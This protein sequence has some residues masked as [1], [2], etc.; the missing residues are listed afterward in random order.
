M[1]A[2]AER[3]GTLFNGFI[4]DMTEA[5]AAEERTRQSEKMEA[6]GQLVGG[7]A[8]DF[9]NLLTVITG[10]IDL[11]AEGVADKPQLLSIARL[12]GEAADRGAELTG[13]LLAFARKQPLQPHDTDINGLVTAGQGL[14]QRA[15]GEQMEIEVILKRVHGRH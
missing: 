5:I 6:V 10:T 11:L 7:I 15:L 12:I 9:N 1:T 14:F 13:H 3:R 2:F 8:H 4:R